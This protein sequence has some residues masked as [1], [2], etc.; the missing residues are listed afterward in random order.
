MLAP[1]ELRE[2]RSIFELGSGSWGAMAMDGSFDATAF[3]NFR[4][5]GL[6]AFT[7]SAWF[8]TPCLRFFTQARARCHN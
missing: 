1:D 7:A 8:F 5:F 4:W 6:D 3:S 2:L